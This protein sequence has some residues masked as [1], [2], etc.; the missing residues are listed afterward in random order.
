MTRGDSAPI[1]EN[2]VMDIYAAFAKAA[3]ERPEHPAVVYL[4]TTYRYV[5]VL[6]L[7]DTFAAGLRAYGVEPGERVMLYIPNSIQWVV[8][9][10]GVLRAGAVSVPVTP[11]YTPSDL[12]QIAADSGARTI[13]CADTN[14]GYVVKAMRES[15][16]ERAIVTNA[17]DLLPF[18]KRLFGFL[19]DVVP[20][21]EVGGEA[22]H[23]AFRKLLALGRRAALPERKPSAEP[24]GGLAEILYTGG[25]TRRH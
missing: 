18:A 16:L 24:E 7:A 6:Q 17:T 15:P 8:A 13:V 19:F 14:F 11:A 9:W 5:E 21:G 1:L 25:T 23:I 4:G 2:N 12:V 10:L 3:A 22:Q 20:T